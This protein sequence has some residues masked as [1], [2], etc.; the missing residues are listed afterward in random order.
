MLGQ[1]NMAGMASRSLR[2]GLAAIAG[3]LLAGCTDQQ[4]RHDPSVV[5]LATA[6]GLKTEVGE[7]KDFVRASR[8]SSIAYVPVE[9]R[10]P[11]RPSPRRA[12]A[13]LP[14]V[15]QELEKDRAK[16]SGFA[17]R[18]LPKS[19]YG[20]VDEARRQARAARALANRPIPGASGQPLTYPVPAGRRRGAGQQGGGPLATPE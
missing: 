13:S 14:G 10:P 18:S 11:D 12:A 7:P 9:V 4:L 16:S 15:E 3:L 19:Q 8:P 2:I 6:T 17:R 5:S 20:G 1:S